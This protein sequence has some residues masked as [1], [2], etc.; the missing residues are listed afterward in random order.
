GYLLIFHI[1]FSLVLNSNDK[2]C[3]NHNFYIQLSHYLHTKHNLYEHNTLFVLPIYE[4]QE[5]RVFF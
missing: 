1:P 2:I 5:S 3:N 4:N